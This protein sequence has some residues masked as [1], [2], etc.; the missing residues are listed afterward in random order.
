MSAVFLA[1]FAI[2]PSSS[3]SGWP[4]GWQGGNLHQSHR[5]IDAIIVNE[6][7]FVLFLV[8]SKTL[9]ILLSSTLAPFF[10][11]NHLPQPK[12]PTLIQAFQAEIPGDYPDP[13]ANKIGDHFYLV[14][15]G[16]GPKG[17]IPMDGPKG[18]SKIHIVEGACIGF[19]FSC[20]CYFLFFKCCCGSSCCCCCC[21][22]SS[23]SSSFSS[24]SPSSSS[25]SFSSYHCPSS[26]STYYCGCCW[27]CWCCWWWWRR[28]LGWFGWLWLRCWY[29]IHFQPCIC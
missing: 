22:S 4:S 11:L 23:S 1:S 5:A 3:T 27:G 25:F 18:E 10:T 15:T 9:G 26:P 28:W 19:V 29:S 6:M 21:C 7:H 2:P 24:S 16:G 8:A 20:Y 12:L 17:G 13:G 14:A